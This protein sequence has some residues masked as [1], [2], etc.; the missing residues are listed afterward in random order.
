MLPL[1]HAH[2]GPCC[3][4]PSAQRDREGGSRCSVVHHARH[5]RPD[6]TRDRFDDND[7]L[8]QG[9]VVGAGAYAGCSL[10]VLT[11]DQLHSLTFGL[12][13]FACSNGPNAMGTRATASSGPRSSP[14]APPK[15]ARGST[16][17]PRDGD[18]HRRALRRERAA[19]DLCR[20]AAVPVLPGRDAGGNGR[21]ELFD[22][23]TSPTGTWYLVEPGRGHPAPGRL[24]LRA[25][26][27]NGEGA[28]GNDG[29]GLLPPAP[30]ELPRLHLQQRNGRAC[31]SYCALTWPPVLTTGRPVA[32]PGVDQRALGFVVLPDGARQVTYRGKP[33]YLFINDA[34][35]PGDQRNAEHQRR[36]CG[37][38]VGCVPH[39]SVDLT[40]LKSRN[41]QVADSIC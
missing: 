16:R 34:Y 4:G 37:H 24:Q 5:Q 32:G 7:I 12:A 25:E 17:P 36:G 22:P 41:P 40:L 30:W 8:W 15:P 3:R 6:R 2:T 20:S 26:T 19:G 35:I 39:D 1:R 31:E 11:S 14:R 33:L 23:V 28:G 38:P 27:V 9:A 21:G 29:Q 13:S 10:Y 18:A